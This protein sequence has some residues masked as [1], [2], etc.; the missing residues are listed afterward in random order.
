MRKGER[1][2]TEVKLVEHELE[3]DVK[4]PMQWFQAM[5]GWQ[6]G[7]LDK[8]AGRFQEQLKQLKEKRPGIVVDKWSWFGGHDGAGQWNRERMKGMLD[9]M[10]KHLEKSNLPKEE[11]ER[12]RR[13]VEEAMESARKAVDDA[14]KDVKRGRKPDGGKDDDKQDAPP[15]KPGEPL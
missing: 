3:P 1:H 15:K 8:N 4:G 2:D 5:P 9:E 6:G 13:S 14:M 11:Q 10:R 12:I 7:L